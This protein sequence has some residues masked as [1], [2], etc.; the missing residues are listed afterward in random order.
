MVVDVTTIPEELDHAIHHP[1]RAAQPHRRDAGPTQREATPTHVPTPAAD[2]PLDGDAVED[3]VPA[4][5]DVHAHR[6]PRLGVGVDPLV[7]EVHLDE[8]LVGDDQGAVERAAPRAEADQ[9]GGTAVDQ[10]RARAARAGGPHAVEGVRLG[11]RTGL[12]EDGG[13]VGVALAETG[14]HQVTP[15]QLAQGRPPGGGVPLPGEGQVK[16][17]G[18]DQGP[19]LLGHR[20]D[21]AGLGETLGW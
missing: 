2:G 21:G 11:H 13:G 8:P 5:G 10:L 17:P 1:H 12:R 4:V 9:P 16:R 19:Q 15:A 6:P 7:P 20:H 3:H 18:G 14:Q